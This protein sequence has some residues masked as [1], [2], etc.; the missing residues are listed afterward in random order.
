M[1]IDIETRRPVDV[2]PDRTAAALAAWLTDHPG[3]EVICRDRAGAY[4]EGARAGAPDALQVADRWHL[5]HN[6]ADAVERTVVRHRAGL[7]AAVDTEHD[8][9]DNATTGGEPGFDPAPDTASESDLERPDPAAASAGSVRGERT[10]RI[11][12]RTRERYTAVHALLDDGRSIRTIA[13]RL[14]IAR[15]TVRRFARAATV[16]ELLVHNGTGRRRSLLEEFK[17]YLHQRFN[18]GCTNA[19]H[20][21]AEIRDRG[22][23]GGVQ[24]LRKYLRTL[25]IAGPDQ[26]TDTPP[27]P[28]SVRRVTGWIMSDPAN[29]EPSTQRRL[30][31]ILAASPPLAA[32]AGHVQAFATMMCQLRGTRLESWMAAVTSDDLPALHSFVTGLRRDHDAV[33]AGLTL[34]YNSGPVEGHVN[35]IKMLKRQ[36]FGR[37][38]LDLLRKRVLLAD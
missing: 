29:L 26:E 6:L 3:V 32:L 38:K 7:A 16:E 35:R 27:K 10:D 11:A 14:G 13:E 24:I 34:P 37:A 25:R 33:T 1:L 18:A 2:L 4:A 30:D 19:A 22:D 9:R 8:P 20:L 5:W 21:L 15:G 28:P 17:P 23:T 36:M 31:A 12:T